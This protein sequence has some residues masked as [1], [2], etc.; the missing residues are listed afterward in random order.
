MVAKYPLLHDP[1]PPAT[2]N[3]IACHGQTVHCAEG[4][5]FA[6]QLCY[7][8]QDWV[9]VSV[10][11]KAGRRSVTQSGGRARPPDCGGCS[12]LPPEG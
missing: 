11:V 9:E 7:G 4:D 12:D 8:G 2:H 1:L 3:N 5:I 10:G 6:L